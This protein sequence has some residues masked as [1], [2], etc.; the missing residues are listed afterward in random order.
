M[1]IMKAKDA[2]TMNPDERKKRL[3]ELNFSLIRGKV[4]A[5]KANSKTKEIKRAIA[6]LLTFANAS[7]EVKK[8]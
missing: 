7:E 6:R 3:Q 2:R 4:T 5:N 1:A 8:N